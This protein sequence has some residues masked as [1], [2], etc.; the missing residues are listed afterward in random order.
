MDGRV[1]PFSRARA[2]PRQPSFMDTQGGRLGSK[3]VGLAGLEEL[4]GAF[5]RTP[6][7]WS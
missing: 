5:E 1:L 3:D 7:A 4:K 6:V 2:Q